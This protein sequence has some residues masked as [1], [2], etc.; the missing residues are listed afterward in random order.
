MAKKP[1]I[2][3]QRIAAQ[4]RLFKVEALDLEFSNGER[5]EYERLQSST[6]GAVLCVPVLND[7]TLLLIREYAAGINDYTLAF[8]K[9]RIEP[10]DT[11]PKEAGNREIKEE[12]GYGANQLT[13]LRSVNL[14]PGYLGHTT[15]IVLAENL[16][17]ERLPGDEPEPVEVVPWPVSRATELLQQHDF[18]ESRSITAL[19]LTLQH[20]GKL[21][22]DA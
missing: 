6:R 11:S 14:A 2:L 13:L 22:L 18:T 15:H 12:V 5:R 10:T 21:N 4:S 9:G 17:E 7:D 1:D 19:F 16:Y 20:L 3:N 8:P